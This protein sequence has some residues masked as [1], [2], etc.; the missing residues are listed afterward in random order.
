MMEAYGVELGR[1]C[2]NLYQSH[3]LSALLLVE[4]VAVEL[5][6]VVFAVV[7]PATVL[8]VVMVVFNHSVPVS[9]FLHFID[10]ICLNHI[11]LLSHSMVNY[12]YNNYIVL[13]LVIVH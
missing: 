2:G 12:I 7:V 5:V 6:A 1:V 4:F 8:V 13:I 3:E 11:T 10:H 9:A